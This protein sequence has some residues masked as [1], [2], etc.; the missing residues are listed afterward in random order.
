MKIKLFPLAQRF[1]WKDLKLRKILMEENSN[2]LFLIAERMLTI[3][4]G[5]TVIDE[6]QLDKKVNQPVIMICDT[7]LERIMIAH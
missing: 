1:L 5:F 3:K 6:I 2:S 4:N 7:L